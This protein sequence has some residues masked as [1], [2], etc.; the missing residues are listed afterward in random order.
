MKQYLPIT[1][2]I[3]LLVLMMS[4]TID[5]A[6][7]DNF[8]NQ[9]QPN[10]ITDDNSA[11]NNP[12]TDA[13]ATLGRVLF[14][15][16]NLSRTNTVACATC[17]IQQFAFGD[18]ARASVGVNGTTG[19]HSMRLANARFA[20][21]VQFFW[22]ERAAT[23]EIQTTQPIQD[24]AEMGY[25]GTNGDP[26]FNDLLVKLDGISYYNDLFYLAFGDTAITE[27]RMQLALAQFVRSIQSFDSPFDIGRAQVN[28]DGQPFPNFTNQENAGKAL[29]LTPPQLDA[30][31]S[32]TG[33]GAG[34][35][36][37]HQPPEFDIDPNSGNNGVT[38][39]IA[40]G[41][42]RD[43]TNTRSPSLRDAFNPN[44]GLN[45]PMMH[46]GNFNTMAGVLNHYDSIVIDPN[47]TNL[48]NRL[49][50]GG[51]GQKLNLTAAERAQ[52]IAFLQTLT[53]TDMYTNAKWSDP[54]D[55]NGSLSLINSP[56]SL[57][58]ASLHNQ[59]QLY[60]IPA[61]AYIQ[62]DGPFRDL[63]YEIHNSQGQLIKKGF[64]ETESGEMD[65]TSFENGIYILSFRD[66]G[67]QL[68]AR[69]NFIV[70]H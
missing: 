4:G 24:H 59:L 54:F 27:T 6:N 52:L 5:L 19:R 34:C 26:D 38:A 40:G 36:G 55:A 44:G 66:S 22:D 35:T 14:Y 3:L 1:S 10:Y 28:N 47:N 21:E 50:A 12:I 61:D 63:D 46:N 70:K 37:C 2:A 31:G 51:N 60:P 20:N 43:Y 7:L 48:D 11:A 67:G 56:L 45:G 15:D 33:G 23:L 13:G 41:G 25:S 30:N 64:F 69:R 18:T 42:V 65:L 57:N 8:A 58:V 49:A 16:K 39:T 32:R 29:F 9:G 17:H 53:G 62:L 68:L